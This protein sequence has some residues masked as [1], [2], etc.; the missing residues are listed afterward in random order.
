MKT[1]SL[2]AALLLVAAACRADDRATTYTVGD[3]TVRIVSDVSLS[4]GGRTVRT[5][6]AAGSVPSALSVTDRGTGERIRATTNGGI[7]EFRVA[8]TSDA[9]PR[10]RIV[11]EADAAGYWKPRGAAF[12]FSAALSPGAN[13][14]VLPA[15]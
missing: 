11:E 4:G 12:A 1:I 6:L 5:P 7:L 10:V 13:E 15:G 2:T 8:G 9:E 3:K 14:I